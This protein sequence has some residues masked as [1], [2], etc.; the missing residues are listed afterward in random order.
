MLDGG[1]AHLIAAWLTE[2]HIAFPGFE[3][4]VVGKLAALASDQTDSTL[5]LHSVTPSRSTKAPKREHKPAREPLVFPRREALPEPAFT[6]QLVL[7]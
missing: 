5:A 1:T 2:Q 4:E 7:F 3:Q 6:Q